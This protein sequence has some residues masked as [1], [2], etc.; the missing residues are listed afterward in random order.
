M[1]R[2][3]RR[4]HIHFIGLNLPHPGHGRTQMAL[5]GIAGNTGEDVNQSV[6]AQFSQKGLFIT[7]G[8]HADDSR[9][10]VWHP[11]LGQ[12]RGWRDDR[13]GACNKAVLSTTSGTNDPFLALWRFCSHRFGQ[14]TAVPK[15]V[16]HITEIL[17]ETNLKFAGNASDVLTI[18]ANLIGALNI[19]IEEDLFDDTCVTIRWLHGIP[20]H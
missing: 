18:E 15:G 5:K 6:V 12:D 13:C 4:P 2:G 8:I 9:C 11:G 1:R 16:H 20:F 10:R 17:G 3:G 19:M 14:L 7:Q